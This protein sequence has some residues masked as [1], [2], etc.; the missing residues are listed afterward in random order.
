MRATIGIWV[1]ILLVTTLFF[2]PIAY[3]LHYSPY[4]I[5]LRLLVTG[6]LRF[7]QATFL[8][9]LAGSMFCIYM[10]GKLPMKLK[11][12]TEDRSLGLS[13]YGSTSLLF[14]TLYL[15]AVVFT[16]PPLEYS[17][18][19]ILPGLVIFFLLGIVIF[20]GPLLS[21]R[22]KL[23][24]TKKEK[25]DWIQQRHGHVIELIESVQNGPIDPILLNELIAIDSIRKDLDRIHTWPFNASILARLA[26]VISSPGHLLDPSLEHLAPV[27]SCPKGPGRR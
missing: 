27:C 21:L 16:F 6:Y 15:G 14:V 26:S 7:I 8:L 24:R 10:W 9:I 13:T 19:T 5:L 11:P 18:P 4:Q 2:D 23:V 3:G 1:I 22:A 12:F 17:N 20:A 25:M